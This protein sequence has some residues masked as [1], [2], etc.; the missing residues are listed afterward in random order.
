MLSTLGFSSKV[1]DLSPAGLS[2]A[3]S[4]SVPLTALWEARGN[5]G[6]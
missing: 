6:N 5:T 2:R 4:V 1:R 3:G